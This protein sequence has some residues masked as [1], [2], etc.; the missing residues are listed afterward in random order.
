[1]VPGRRGLSRGALVAA[2]VIAVVLLLGSVAATVAYVHAGQGSAGVARFEERTPFGDQGGR[3]GRGGP[4]WQAPAP[5]TDGRSDD[6]RPF[7]PAV[8][9]PAPS[10][11]G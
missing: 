8:P 7:E 10:V 5:G 2:L 6:G 1:V 3:S 11:A 4:Q 9:R